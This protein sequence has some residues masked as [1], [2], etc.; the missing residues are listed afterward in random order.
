MKQASYYRMFVCT[1]TWYILECSHELITGIGH[2]PDVHGA[3]IDGEA[4]QQ[5]FTVRLL[6]LPSVALDI[7]QEQLGDPTRNS[8]ISWCCDH[9]LHSED[10]ARHVFVCFC[11]HQCCQFMAWIGLLIA[12]I[13]YWYHALTECVFDMASMTIKNN[14]WWKVEDKES[15]EINF[16]GGIN[17]CK[18]LNMNLFSTNK[19]E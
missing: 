1:Y 7:H 13:N 5:K 15:P 11:V 16:A 10:F 12:L 8:L 6:Q 2:H 3:G 4:C 18:I 17:Y 14:E 9:S 19:Q